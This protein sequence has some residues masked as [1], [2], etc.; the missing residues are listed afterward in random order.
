MMFF[1]DL[2][3]DYHRPSDTWDKI[4]AEGEK[5]ILKLVKNVIIDLSN[6]KEKPQ[7]IKP[8]TVS[9]PGRD[10]PGFRVSTGIIPQFGEQV[11]GVKIQG[12][13]EGSAAAKAGL[14]SGDIIIKLGDNTIKNLYDYTY[15]LSNHKPG[16]KV[17]IIWIR[18]GKQMS[19]ELEF[20][21]R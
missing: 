21:K 3:M 9:A 8:K 19:N 17:T 4:N 1:T 7:F 6:T 12:T 10:M 18:D 5:N 13:K 16:D 15:A 2:H 11:E 20:G 14:K